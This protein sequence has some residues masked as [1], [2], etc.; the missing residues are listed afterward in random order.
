LVTAMP[1]PYVAHLGTATPA[2][3]VMG[4]GGRPSSPKRYGHR[5]DGQ[6]MPRARRGRESSAPRGSGAVAPEGL[7]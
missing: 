6:A 4:Q 3:S 7:G 5:Y 2:S 1:S